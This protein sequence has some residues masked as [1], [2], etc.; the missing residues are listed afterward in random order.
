MWSFFQEVAD[1]CSQLVFW[2]NNFIKSAGSAVSHIGDVGD[3][4]TA[5][6]YAPLGLTWVFPVCLSA[7]VFWFVRRV[8]HL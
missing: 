6:D 7:I 8:I 3:F 2:L 1:F 4:I 5:V